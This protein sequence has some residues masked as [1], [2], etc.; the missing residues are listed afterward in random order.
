VVVTG[1]SLTWFSSQ[2]LFRRAPLGRRHH[3]YVNGKGY[4]STSGERRC[5]RRCVC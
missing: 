3:E 5:L 1:R 4:P 2:K